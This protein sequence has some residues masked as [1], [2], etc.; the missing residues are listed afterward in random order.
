MAAFVFLE[1]TDRD[2]NYLLLGIQEILYGSRPKRAAHLTIRGPYSRSVTQATLKS[3]SDRLK[4]DVLEI[5][6]VGRFSNP[7]EEVVYVNVTSPNLRR[8]WWKPDYPIERF[9]FNPHISLYRGPD[10]DLATRVE[11][12]FKH[13]N[14]RLLCAEFRI[15][16]HVSRSAQLEIFEPQV[17]RALVATGRVSPNLLERLTVLALRQQRRSF[18]GIVGDT[19]DPR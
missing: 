15:V 2:I 3:L 9:G 16:A 4:Y 17:P 6:G 14:L 13:E 7:L 1:I 19:G 12:F 11:T 5:A 8:V 18:L 10:S